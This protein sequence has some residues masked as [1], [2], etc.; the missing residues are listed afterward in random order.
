MFCAVS[1]L[2]SIVIRRFNR[3]LGLVVALAATGMKM[4]IFVRSKDLQNRF[5][6]LHHNVKERE[7]F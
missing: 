1:A 4:H 2:V 3:D 6:E 5:G 7:H